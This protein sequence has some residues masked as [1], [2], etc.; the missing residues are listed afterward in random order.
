VRLPP[1]PRAPPRR[2][3]RRHRLDEARE[4]GRRA[5]RVSATRTVSCDARAGTGQPSGSCTRCSGVWHANLVLGAHA[6][7]QG[8]CAFC[9]WAQGPRTVCR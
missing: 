7:I 9:F 3:Q 1:V 2:S 8:L 5:R 6:S 4:G